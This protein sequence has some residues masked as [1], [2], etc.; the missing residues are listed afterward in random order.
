[1]H[2]KSE[3]NIFQISLTFGPELALPKKLRLAKF[4][5]DQVKVC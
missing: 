2:G 1:M 5:A 4:E 3:K